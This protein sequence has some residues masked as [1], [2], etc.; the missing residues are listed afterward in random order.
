MGKA[1]MLDQNNITYLFNLGRLYQTRGGKEDNEL[2]EKIFKKVLGVNDKEINT[3]FSLGLLYEKTQRK[4][5]AISEYK[6]V[7]DLLPAESADVRERIEK[8]ITNIESGVS[9]ISDNLK[10]ANEEQIPLQ[11]A[12][13]TR[14]EAVQPA[15]QPVE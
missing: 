2:A 10:G 9:N 6:A 4:N 11:P 13:E 14:E 1:A 15:E 5:E 3:H 7:L 12:E 8:M